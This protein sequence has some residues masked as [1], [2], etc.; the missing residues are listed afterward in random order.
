MAFDLESTVLKSW[1]LLPV[2]FPPI[3]DIP[4][5]AL[6]VEKWPGPREFWFLARG[7]WRRSG[8][9]H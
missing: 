5:K 9:H 6:T 3:A 4:S 7:S 2:R 8:R 1:S